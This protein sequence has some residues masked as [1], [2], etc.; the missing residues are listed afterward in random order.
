MRRFLAPL[1]ELA[2]A[3]TSLHALLGQ[4]HASIFE[5]LAINLDDTEPLRRPEDRAKF[6]RRLTSEFESIRILGS[7]EAATIRLR[8]QYFGSSNF[9]IIELFP[10]PT[11]ARR[12]IML[13]YRNGDVARGG[14]SGVWEAVQNADFGLI[15]RSVDLDDP[16]FIEPY[17]GQLASYQGSNQLRPSLRQWLETLDLTSFELVGIISHGWVKSMD[18][19]GRFTADT[20]SD[21]NLQAFGREMRKLLNVETVPFDQWARR[22]SGSVYHVRGYREF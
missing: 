8:A 18:L 10:D 6:K 5:C 11:G 21:M 13:K 9:D 19:Y 15:W 14:T 3:P 2:S 12:F 7:S 16:S 4:P 1:E 17:W 22:N 20:G